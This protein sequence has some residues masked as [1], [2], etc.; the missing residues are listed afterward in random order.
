MKDDELKMI[1]L[2]KAEIEE[3]QKFFQ[4]IPVF[5][6]IYS[7]IID[8]LDVEIQERTELCMKLDDIVHESCF[9]NVDYDKKLRRIA[10]VLKNFLDTDNLCADIKFL[11]SEGFKGL[12]RKD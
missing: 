9:M 3:K 2:A 11:E 10:K 1:E 12:I 8:M 6:E 5:G 4:N 7:K